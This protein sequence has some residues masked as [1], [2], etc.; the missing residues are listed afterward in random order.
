MPLKKDG[1]KGYFTLALDKEVMEKLKNEAKR[2]DRSF[3][4]LVRIILKEY[5]DKVGEQDA[6]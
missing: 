1:D 5:V 2:Q 3:S 4:S 6:D